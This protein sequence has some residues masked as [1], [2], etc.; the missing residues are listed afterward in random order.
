MQT[1]FDTDFAGDE[2]IAVYVGGEFVYDG[3]IDNLTDE[4]KRKYSRFDW[5]SLAAYEEYDIVFIG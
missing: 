3:T 4:Q 5:Y 2:N 1:I